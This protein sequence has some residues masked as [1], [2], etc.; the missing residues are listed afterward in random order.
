MGFLDNEAHRMKNLTPHGFYPL[1]YL[2]AQNQRVLFVSKD[3][4]TYTYSI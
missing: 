3:F 1:N 4:K 2:L